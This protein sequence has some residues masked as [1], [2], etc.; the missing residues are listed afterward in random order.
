MSDQHEAMTQEQYESIQ[1]ACAVLAAK[2]TEH[3]GHV[4]GGIAHWVAEM[5]EALDQEVHSE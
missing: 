3:Y 5:H 1:P 4:V 2:L